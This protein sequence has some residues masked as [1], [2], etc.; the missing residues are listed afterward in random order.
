MTVWGTVSGVRPHHGVGVGDEVPQGI[1]ESL[2]L[3]HLG[4]DVVELG[5]AHRR[6][7]PNVGVLVLQTLPQRLAQILCDLVHSDAAHG[8]HGQGPDEGVGVLAVLRR[9][10]TMRRE[11]YSPWSI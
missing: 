2:V 8:A 6:R 5:H 9:G 3:H 10:L 11:S 7:L 4:V 1:Q